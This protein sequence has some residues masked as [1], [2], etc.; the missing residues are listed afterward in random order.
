VIARW[1]NHICSR[2]AVHSVFIDGLLLGSAV[3]VL[4][5]VI[6]GRCS[7]PIHP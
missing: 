1:I 6:M 7:A 4:V 2:L 5:I 3:G